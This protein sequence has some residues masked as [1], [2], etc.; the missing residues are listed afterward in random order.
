MVTA[1]IFGLIL[2]AG[3]AYW[4][5]SFVL[6]LRLI[7]AT[8][9]LARLSP[10]DPASWP[11]LSVIIP[12]CNEADTLETAMRSCLS[13][14]Y[15]NIEFIL[16]NDRSTDDTGAIADRLA[17]ADSRVR[18]LHITEL[19]DGWLGKVH[20]LHVATQHATGEWLL[21]IDADV[22]LAPGTLRRA[23]AWCEQ[24]GRDH[25]TLIPEFWSSTFLLDTVMAC[26]MRIGAIGSRIWAVENPRS[27]AS[28]GIGAFNLVRREALARTPGL[29]WLKLEVVDDIALGQMLKRHGARSSVANG[30]GMV[31][32][33]WYRSVP[34]MARGAEKNAFAAIGRYSV[35]RALT[36]SV[37]YVLV[38]WSPLLACVPIGVWWMQIAGAIGLILAIAT[39]VLFCR[40]M[41]RPVLA[42]LAFPVGA[43][44]FAFVVLRS[45]YFAIRRGGLLW[46]GTLYP[47]KVLRGG[48]R[49][50]FP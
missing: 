22:H 12:A 26:F 1:W 29:E 16:V 38:E 30:R 46:R 14:D 24:R 44:I 11:R 15:P 17:A 2:I 47:T 40:W 4:L 50:N 31:Q 33:H 32:L 27:S 13:D 28:I 42:G 45:G 36:M 8:P 18:A 10:P 19:P 39:V 20:A 37:L 43:A 9:V 6:T 21:F 25:L 7:R 3:C 23:V 5:I 49:F 35:W 41:H 48:R 34:E